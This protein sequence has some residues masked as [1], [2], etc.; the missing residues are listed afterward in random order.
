MKT[1]ILYASKHGTTQ[2]TAHEICSQLPQ[3]VTCVDIHHEKIPPLDIYDTAIVGTS[4]HAGRTSKRFQRFIKEYTPVLLNKKL[5]LFLCC[6]EKEEK[7][8]AQFDSAFPEELR[9]HATQIMLPGGEFLFDQ[10]NFFEKKIIERIS[11]IKQTT[12]H[13]NHELIEEFAHEFATSE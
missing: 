7:A 12:S 3:T 13:L 2:K 10:M 6:M 4:I 5:G 11:G 1:I 8:E 9:L